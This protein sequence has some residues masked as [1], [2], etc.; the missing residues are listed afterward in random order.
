MST[1][2]SFERAEGLRARGLVFEQDYRAAVEGHRALQT[3]V[4]ATADRL[5]IELEHKR[6]EVQLDL[7]RVLIEVEG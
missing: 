6:L 5:A 7:A 3:R 2:Q 4:L 1:T